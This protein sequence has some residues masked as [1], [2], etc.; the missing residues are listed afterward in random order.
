[1]DFIDTLF[2]GNNIMPEYQF[3]Y[4]MHCI[5]L[6]ICF[7]VIIGPTIGVIIHMF[8]TFNNIFNLGNLLNTII[9]ILVATV[10]ILGRILLYYFYGKVKFSFIIV[11]LLN[12][13]IITI[14]SLFI[15][16]NT[17]GTI[18]VLLLLVIDSFLFGFRVTNKDNGG[19]ARIMLGALSIISIIL[20]C[21]ILV[22]FFIFIGNTFFLR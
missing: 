2:I 17:I 19:I 22:V 5:L 11:M 18:V 14:S 20:L 13:I 3:F 12:V 16:V 9:S 6:S 1:M 7:V 15:Y 8:N 21:A 4:R 10:I